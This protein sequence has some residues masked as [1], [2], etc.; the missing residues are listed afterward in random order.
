M[1]PKRNYDFCSEAYIVEKTIEV[2]VNIADETRTIRIEALSDLNDGHYC[3]R[4]YIKENYTIQPTYPQ[5]HGQYDKQPEESTV[6]IRYDLPWT[7]CKTA[8][9]ALSQALGFLRERFP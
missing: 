4:S 6:W 1:I 9:E 3:T 8:D 2:V 7:N 5:T